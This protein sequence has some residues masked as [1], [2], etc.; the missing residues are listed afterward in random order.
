M[1]EGMKRWHPDSEESAEITISE[2]LSD[3]AFWSANQRYQSYMNLNIEILRKE[4]GISGQ[5]IVNIPVLFHPVP[6]GEYTTAYFPDMIN[7]L[8]LGE[9]SIV[10]KP[11][12]PII[13]GQCAFEQ[14]FEQAVPDRKVRFV[15]NWYTY[16]EMAGE[17]HCATNTLRHP[18]AN[19]HWWNHK[20]DGGF[21]I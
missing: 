6:I 2:L 1:F 11:K 16:H 14:A 20:P 17:I 7:H 4:L 5:Y 19:E 9:T 8:V 18:F 13:N 12:G 21:D 3:K 15:D 10:P